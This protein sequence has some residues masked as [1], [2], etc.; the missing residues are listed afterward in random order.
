MVE[1]RLEGSTVGE[2]IDALDSRFPG[3]ERPPL[4]RRPLVPGLQV[5]IDEV[6]TRRGL[7][8]KVRTR[9]RGPFPACDWW[10]GKNSLG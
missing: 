8:A 7:E 5:S 1:I 4:P 6:M 9:Q 10:R 3:S 2:L